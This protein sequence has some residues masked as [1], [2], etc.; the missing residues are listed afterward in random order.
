[1]RTEETSVGES[2]KEGGITCCV[3]VAFL[4]GE[5]GWVFTVENCFNPYETKERLLV[6]GWFRKS[7]P[8][9]QASA[10]LREPPLR[11]AGARRRKIRNLSSVS[12]RFSEDENQKQGLF[13][14][15]LSTASYAHKASEEDNSGRCFSF[16]LFCL[17]IFL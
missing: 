10:N 16:P 12:V 14:A 15:V 3:Y 7:Y 8:M 13:E 2:L 1:M 17:H 5:E 11:I 4:R 6:I 9:T